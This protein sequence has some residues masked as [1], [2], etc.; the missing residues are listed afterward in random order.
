MLNEQLLWQAVLARDLRWDGAFVYAVQST[1]IYC[2]PTCP[3]RRPHRDRVRFFSAAA[4]A[5]QAGFRA[6]RRCLP[7]TAAAEPATVARVR[8]VC[9]AIARRPDGRLTLP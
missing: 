7:S 8:R 4:A 6:C 3:S 2:R 1:R 9:A 5:E